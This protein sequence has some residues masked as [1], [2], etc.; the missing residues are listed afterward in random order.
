MLISIAATALSLAGFALSTELWMLFVARFLHGAF[1]AN[2]STAQAYVADVTR[3]EDR[4]R[5]MGLIGASFGVGFTLGPWVGGELSVWGMTAPIWLACALSS[6]NFVW[7]LFGLPESTT[8]RTRHPRRLSPFAVFRGVAHPVVGLAILLTFAATLAF[9]MMEFAFPLV[10]EHDWHMDQRAVGR[11]FGII[12][13][14]GI[15]VQGGLIRHLVRRFGEARLVTAGYLF[16]MTGLL[17]LTV[18]TPGLP[19]LAACVAMAVGASISN[20][21]LQAIVSRGAGDDEQGA[22]LGINQGMSAMAR[23]ISPWAALALY[24]PAWRVAPFLGAAVVLAAALGL[25]WPA[26]R[27]ATA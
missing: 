4:A 6:I 22:V 7:A 8:A 23:A 13:V 12:G 3:P 21:S 9:A 25:S 1:A 20:P 27:R 10:A 19:L 18:A 17:G 14:V 5:G 16:T 11:F 24:S 26:T 15:V 2:I